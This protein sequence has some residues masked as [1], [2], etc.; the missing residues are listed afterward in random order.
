MEDILLLKTTVLRVVELG[1]GLKVCSCLFTTPTPESQE[2]TPLES[3][4]LF[5]RL[6]VS[7]SPLPESFLVLL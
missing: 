5:E 4:Q 3:V 2:L 6:F 7:C 1:I